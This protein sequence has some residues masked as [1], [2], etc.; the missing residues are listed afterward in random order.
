MKWG[1]GRKE[2]GEGRVKMG[3]KEERERQSQRDSLW[4]ARIYPMYAFS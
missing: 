3:E 4:M 2:E 1:K